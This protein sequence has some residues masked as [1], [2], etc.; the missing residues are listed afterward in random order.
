MRKWRSSIAL[1]AAFTLVAAACGDDEE[2]PKSE[3]SGSTDDSGS[4][5]DALKIGLVY[6]I[7]GRGD[8]SFNDAAAAGFDKAVDEFGVEATELEPDEGGEN[9]EELLRQLAEDQ[10]LVIAVGFAFDESVGKASTDFPD[11]KFAQVDGGVDAANVAELGFA[12]HEGSFLVGAAAALKSQTGKVGFIGGVEIELIQ[13]FEAG[14][15]AG[16][17]YINPDIEVEVQYISPAGDFSG[18]GAPDKAKTIAEAMYEGGADVVYHAAGGSGSGLFEAAAATGREGEVWAIG[19]DSDQYLTAPADQQPY[20]L[21]SML[22]RVDVAVY[23]TIK[24]LSEGTFEAGFQTF[25][26]SVDGVGYSSSNDAI[27]DISSQ[28]DEIATKIASGE[29]EVPTVP[30]G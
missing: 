6:D 21:T 18:F 15:V 11:A 8:K 29:I 26:L 2:D 27:S 9:R 1:L 3:T 17:K 5:E 30:E 19:V 4:S 23:E 22:K 7:G 24:A 12:E 20:I 10:D 25:D 16:A 14:Y 28:L 13:K